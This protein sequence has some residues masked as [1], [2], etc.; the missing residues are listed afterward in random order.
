[1]T[2]TALLTRAEEVELGRRALK[3]DLAAR[4][5]LIRANLRLVTSVARRWKRRGVPLEDLVQE[6]TRGL[7]RG[8]DRFDPERVTKLSTYVTWWIRHFIRQAC[9]EVTVVSIPRYQTDA[10]SAK[11]DPG[12]PGRKFK[13]HV[14]AA[15]NPVLSIDEHFDADARTERPDEIA[16]ERDE[17]EN[18]YRV[19]GR[20][21]LTQN[22]RYVLDHRYGLGG[23]SPET[24][25]AIGDALNLT[26][27]RIRQIELAAVAK[28]RRR[29]LA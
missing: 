20:A 8:V 24:L 4:D 16:A 28:I 5:H 1:V 3:G 10:L 19:I 21:G 22:E 11:A 18:L 12:R 6:G 15:R 23:G 26:R 9:A 7:I 29:M 27:E 13:G 25:K 14:E 17:R 2:R